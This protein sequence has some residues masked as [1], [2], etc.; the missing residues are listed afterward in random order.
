[1]RVAQRLR[2]YMDAQGL[3]Y[4]RVAENSGF[5]RSKFSLI[6]NERRRLT[7]DEL[8]KVCESGLQISPAIFFAY[9][10]PKNKNAK[11]KNLKTVEL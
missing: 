1:M 3:K 2:A 9:K 8:V 11:R 7:A 10:F 6:L 4:S 5:D